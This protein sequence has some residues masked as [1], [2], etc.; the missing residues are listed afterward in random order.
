MRPVGATSSLS[1]HSVFFVCPLFWHSSLWLCRS[2][3]PHEFDV[4]ARQL[5]G[6]GANAGHARRPILASEPLVETGIITASE[7]GTVLPL[8]NWA[9]SPVHN[10][11]LAL[12][13]RRDTLPFL[14]LPLS[15]NQRLMSLLVVL[16]QFDVHFT[17]ARR[18]SGLPLT[19]ATD[20]HGRAVFT[21]DLEVADAIVLR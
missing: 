17:T 6:L 11:M 8:I 16:L 12:Q 13:V 14:A 10:L 21:L 9:G 5:I 4:A 2:F 7:R 20:A 18:G 19:H 15:F 1:G 3:V